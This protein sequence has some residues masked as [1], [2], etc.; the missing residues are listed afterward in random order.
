V[1]DTV[2]GEKA[3]L[4][5]DLPLLAPLG[6]FAKRVPPRVL[7]LEDLLNLLH[8]SSSPS[9]FIGNGS[10]LVG[11][12]RLRRKRCRFAPDGRSLGPLKFLSFHDNYRPA[13]HGT[14][15]KTL[16]FLTPRQRCLLLT[17]P[18]TTTNTLQKDCE[19]VLPMDVETTLSSSYSSSSYPPPS[20]SLAS[21]RRDPL[22]RYSSKE[23]QLDYEDDSDEEWESGNDEDEGESLSGD[24]EEESNNNNGEELAPEDDMFVVPDGYL[25]DDEEG[26]GGEDGGGAKRGISGTAAATTKKWLLTQTAKPV[27]LAPMYSSF[28]T[29][30]SPELELFKAQFPFSL[31]SPPPPST[32]TSR[33]PIPIFQTLQL[34]S[35]PPLSSSHT[36]PVSV[37]PPS[38]DTQQQLQQQLRRSTSFTSEGSLSQLP[39]TPPCSLSKGPC[40]PG[41]LLPELVKVRSFSL[42]LPPR[43]FPFSP[44]ISGI[45][46][47]CIVKR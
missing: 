13:F 26:G 1:G 17:P 33:F 30:N 8:H 42:P 4:L 12:P 15:S 19:D 38:S 31:Y 43:N 20:T 47:V 23:G 44:L 16:S 14:C 11:L 22:H 29:T 37:G 39:H 7:S 45:S 27:I 32:P 25:S 46:R 28:N 21:L 35:S 10:T 41:S 5:G 36:T 2:D 40:F 24:D 18:K 3:L 6:R 9:F 34:S